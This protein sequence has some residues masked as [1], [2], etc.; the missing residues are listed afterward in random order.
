MNSETLTLIDRP[1]QE[2]VDDILT[3]IT[4]GVVNE[5]IF[6]DIKEDF[7]PLARP[8]RDV[9]GITGTLSVRD[10]DGLLKPTRHTFQKLVDY[11]FRADDN[12]V[13]WQPGAAK[14]DDE[15]IF[16]VDYFLRESRSP[17]TDLNVGSVTR[18]LGEAIGREIATVYQQINQAYLAG[19]IDMATGKSLELVV[20]ILGI[21]RK[22]KEFA[23]GLATFFRD[24]AAGDGNITIPEGTVLS[25]EKGEATFVT[26]QLA[27][28]HRGQARI[29]ISVRAG[30]SSP[31]EAGIVKAGAITRL[32]QSIT[33][34]SRVTNFED[35]L[36]GAEDETDEQLRARAK[37]ALRALGKATLAALIN[38][39]TEGRAK[40]IEI[41]DPNSPPIKQS[42]PGTVTL[43]IES[44]P[45]RFLSLRAAVEQTRAAGVQATL[46]A[47]YVFIKPRMRVGI[48]AG[49]TAAGK[50]KV[51]NEIIDAMQKYVDSLG[52]GDPVKGE[53]LLKAITGVKDVKKANTKIVDVMAWQSDVGQPGRE[54]LVKL[55][56]DTVKTS[57]TID[58]STDSD[59]RDK[60]LTTA[61]TNVLSEIEP[62]VPTGRRIPNRNLVQ[63][64]TGQR[65]TDAEIEEG[66]FQVVAVIDNQNWWIVLD[67]EPADIVVE[68]V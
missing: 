23:V 25:T 19:F 54:S 32:S 16:Y 56:V 41:F 39:V 48:A 45:E 11:I 2:I 47:R 29:D 52:A 10:A 7:Y 67:V 66:K 17:L 4:G 34:I 18:T 26:V 33:G 49:L 5:P 43:I 53:E 44:E 50:V 60:S 59:A 1:Y 28:L 14:P 27:T 36:L 40:I 63:G 15:T 38:A 24:Q 51:V 37:A 3:A 9:R 35:T 58:T 6:F 22:T 13:I 8:A 21:K 12:A 30:N 61:I 62:L 42:P 68:E 55:L 20:S 65:A 31:G 57:V 46:I 64:S